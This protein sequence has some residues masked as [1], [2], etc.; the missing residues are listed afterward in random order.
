MQIETPILVVGGGTGGVAAALAALR[1]GQRVVL[2]EE[3]SWLG[4]QLTSQAV[5]PDENLWIETFGGTS[6]YR[7]LRREIRDYYRRYYPLSRSARAEDALS[8]GAGRVSPLCFEP[9]AA[10]A[11]IDG[12]LAPYVTGGR[13]TVLTGTR[14]QHVTTDGDRITSVTFASEDR[15]T[16]TVVADYVLDATELGDLL[17]LSGAEWV[18]G[19]ES[20]ATTGELH[21]LEGEAQPLDQQAITWCFAMDYRDGENWTIDRPANYDFWRS[22]TPEFWPG[23]LLSWTDV[24][25]I[26]LEARTQPLVA[27]AASL[28][29]GHAIDRWTYR[30]ILSVRSLEPGFL[31][32]DI[33]LVNWPQNDYFLGP[34]IGVD[35]AEKQ[36]NID[37]SQELSRSLLYWMQTEAPRHDGGTG[38]PELRLQWFAQRPYVREARRIAAEVTVVEEHLGVEARAASGRPAGSELFEDSVGIGCYRID[39][40]PSTG[41]GTP[42]TYVD[43]AV[44]PFQIPLGALL[45]VRLD[46]L[47]PAAKNIGTT[48][49][50]NG[51]YRTH[52]VEWNIGEAAGALA[53]YCLTTGQPPRAVRGK[54]DHLADYQRVLTGRLGVELAW[55]DRVRKKIV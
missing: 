33:T 8:P 6:S 13:L 44:H 32:S 36:R 39:L 54:P 19:A 18:T 21:A 1:L 34:L 43:I 5:P 29:G 42:R 20:R 46:N 15:D 25:P 27:E 16:V 53:A 30:R 28:T 55:P 52:P 47:L 12:L 14:P 37:A 51:C 49:I 31:T 3:S 48:H 7:T 11:A 17:E 26:T 9:K 50:T 22:Y 35:A 40:H 41:S 10:L 38:Y 4:G 45:P 23:P 24:V 2:T